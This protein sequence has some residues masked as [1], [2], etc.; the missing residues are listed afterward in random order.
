MIYLTISFIFDLLCSNII[1]SAYQNINFF[2]PEILVSS[3]PISYLLIKNK[4]LFFTFVVILSLIYDILFSD[5]FLMNL[6]YFLLYSFLIHM[7]Y[8]NKN[9][10]YLNIIF[11]SLLGII[12]YDIFIFFMLI[13]INYSTFKIDYLVYKTERTVLFNLLYV[14]IS[15]IILKSRIFGFKSTNNY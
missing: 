1:S 14:L 2:Y 5:I 13:F 15:I 8:S 3:I 12:F 11:I 9:S 4:K 7:Y 10:S 6:Y